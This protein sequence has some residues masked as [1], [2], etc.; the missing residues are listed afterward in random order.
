MPADFQ[1]E[2]I[3]ILID[4]YKILN[5][6]LSLDLYQKKLKNLIKIEDKKNKQGKDQVVTKP[7][8]SPNNETPVTKSIQFSKKENIEHLDIITDLLTYAH[9]I[10]ET[11]N[12]REYLRTFFIK[13]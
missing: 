4:L 7:D 11:K 12:L 1:I 8:F 13:C 10:A 2:A 9:Q 6:K 3:N 5:N